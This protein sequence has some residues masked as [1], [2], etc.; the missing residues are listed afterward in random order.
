MEVEL[1]Q[2]VMEVEQTFG[3][4]LPDAEIAT[5]ATVGQ[6]QDCIAKALSERPE[7]TQLEPYVCQ[8]LCRSLESARGVSRQQI[9]STTRL[10]EIIPIRARRRTWRRLEELLPLF[11]PS[12]R[13]PRIVGLLVVIAAVV[14]AWL[15]TFG[16]SNPK[17]VTAEPAVAMICLF[18]IGPLAAFFFVV[19]HRLTT[20]L[21]V[22]WNRDIQTVGNLTRAVV[23]LNHDELSRPRR[24]WSDEEIRDVLRQIIVDVLGVD[25]GQVTREA[26]FAGDGDGGI[27]RA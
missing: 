20:P 7:P 16:P 12:L 4:R 6:L 24:P 25:P 10:R 21:A 26:R 8:K 23:S 22:V 17:W 3:V 1:A 9:H 11:L 19:G 2:V 27:T 5:I 13:R 14:L 18:F 15:C